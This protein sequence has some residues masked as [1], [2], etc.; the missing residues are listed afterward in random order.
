MEVLLH[1][2]LR[3]RKPFPYQLDPRREEQ[4]ADPSRDVCPGRDLSS[5]L[6]ITLGLDLLLRSVSH[7][8]LFSQGV[9]GSNIPGATQ[10]KLSAALSQEYVK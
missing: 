9:D 2:G 5:K 6:A 8:G 7:G 10:P 3:L 4:L 1:Q